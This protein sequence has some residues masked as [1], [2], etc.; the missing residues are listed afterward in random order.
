MGAK[1]YPTRDVSYR[2]R[3]RRRGSG[4]RATGWASPGAGRDGE[5]RLRRRRR[6][7][8]RRI[9][10]AATDGV[11]ATV[12]RHSTST[13]HRGA[14]GAMEVCENEGREW[15]DLKGTREKAA[16]CDAVTSIRLSCS[17]EMGSREVAGGGGMMARRR[18]NNA[19]LHTPE[20]PNLRCWGRPTAFHGRSTACVRR[21]FQ[22]PTNLEPGPTSTPPRRVCQ[23]RL[24]FP[25]GP[26]CLLGLP[27]PPSHAAPRRARLP[28]AIAPNASCGATQ[29]SGPSS[30]V[31]SFSQPSHQPGRSSRRRAKTSPKA[32]LRRAPAPTVLVADPPR[33]PR[34]RRR[35]GDRMARR[36]PLGLPGTLHTEYTY[37][38]PAPWVR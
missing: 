34:R 36:R 12:G 26:S 8:Q 19:L 7:R 23:A 38:R 11:G 17:E 18:A 15:L 14:A 21:R 31:S 27:L 10:A 13:T 25:L 37:G 24:H 30:P 9:R 35:R 5:V 20:A 4:R 28:A 6:R 33:P 2:Q 22:I 32:R 3:G 29:R 16:R 1:L